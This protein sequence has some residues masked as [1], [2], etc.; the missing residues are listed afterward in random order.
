MEGF[1]SNL[2]DENRRLSEH[3][4]IEV[5]SFLVL[6]LHSVHF[7]WR[8]CD[9]A[10]VVY[11]SITSCHYDFSIPN[12]V[13]GSIGIVVLNHWDLMNILN[14]ADMALIEHLV[15]NLPR[16]HKG[17]DWSTPI[18]LFF[19]SLKT[20]LLMECMTLMIIIKTPNHYP[21]RHL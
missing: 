7:L 18:Y 20:P 15:I 9:Y 13:V 19:S 14:H 8:H 2:V 17:A 3:W 21:F 12:M 4:S 10:L 5:P 11:S 16:S 1:Y 6:G